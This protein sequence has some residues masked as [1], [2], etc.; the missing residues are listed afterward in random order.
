MFFQTVGV[1]FSTRFTASSTTTSHV[2]CT[3][4]SSAIICLSY[5]VCIVRSN[6]PIYNSRL[7]ELFPRDPLNQKKNLCQVHILQTKW[8]ILNH[9]CMCNSL[10]IVSLNPKNHHISILQK[11]SNL[12]NL[13]QINPS[14]IH[15]YKRDIFRQFGGTRDTSSLF[16]CSDQIKYFFP[17]WRG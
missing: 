16:L 1:L 5:C 11:K 4:I 3:T 13:L 6:T 17:V 7:V 9:I 15:W 8:H 10:Q 14:P 2:H 12:H